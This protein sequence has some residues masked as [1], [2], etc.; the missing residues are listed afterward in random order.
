M[1]NEIQRPITR[2]NLD[3]LVA[4]H[5]QQRSQSS[6]LRRY[7]GNN[8]LRKNE[9]EYINVMNLQSYDKKK[10]NFDRQ[11][12][13]QSQTQPT[14]ESAEIALKPTAVENKIKEKP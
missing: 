2:Q 8:N 3:E 4:K 9:S 6:N 13:V 5:K 7:T 1:F 11:K 12:M 14:L 10:E